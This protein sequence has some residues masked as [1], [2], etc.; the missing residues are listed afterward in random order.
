MTVREAIAGGT[1]KLAGNLELQ[2]GAARDAEMLLLHELGISRAGLL[3]HPERV[4]V[5]AE[6]ARYEANLA[7][8]LACE[9]I[10]YIVGEQE[11][12]GLRLRVTRDVLIPRPETEHLVE[13]VLARLRGAVRVLDVG[14][15][16]G[17][18]ALALAAN[19]P[20][21]SVTA[22]DLSPAALA[23]AA[24]NA[25]TLGL[26][27]RVRFLESD[28]LGAV[29]GE[30]FDAVVSNPPYVPEGDRTGLAAQVREFEPELALFGGASG[31]NVYERLIPQ[32]ALA[33]KV[34]GL[35]AMEIGYG[36]REAIAA[37]LSGWAG[38][39]FVDDLQGIARVVLARRG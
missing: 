35:L 13:A 14:T 37:L 25:Q 19:L 23:V 17:A 8:R 39:S 34:G 29:R 21:A 11:F 24:G 15:G 12:Y 27:G 36:Q 33:L 18:I 30:V 7:R 20:E 1:R 16:S 28:L 10:Q 2:A 5:D 4:L 38:V 26:V 3:A 6:L 32:A 31:M 22:V 9:P